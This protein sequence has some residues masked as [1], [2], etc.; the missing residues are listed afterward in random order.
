MHSSVIP[1]N[2]HIPLCTGR[3]GGLRKSNVYLHGTSNE[4]KDKENTAWNACG[5][6][7]SGSRG[8]SI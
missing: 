3:R 5:S 7:C 2:E 1:G 8:S 4:E 6:C